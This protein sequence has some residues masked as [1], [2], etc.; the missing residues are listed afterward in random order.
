MNCR[1]QSRHIWGGAACFCHYL[2][3]P[4]FTPILSSPLEEKVI[5]P[6]DPNNVQL[7]AP[8]YKVEEIEKQLDIIAKKDLRK[9]DLC[10][11][12][13]HLSLFLLNW[14]WCKMIK[15]DTGEDW[16]CKYSFIHQSQKEMSFGFIQNSIIFKGPFFSPFLFVQGSFFFK[17][18]HFCS[19]DEFIDQ[20]QEAE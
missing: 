4:G 11:I 10:L 18:G 1:I 14:L 3:C 13:L 12:V 15:N 19:V 6:Q 20:V 2:V 7:W 9:S 8:H 16:S 17:L 5:Y